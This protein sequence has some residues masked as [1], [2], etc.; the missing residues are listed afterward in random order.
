MKIDIFKVFDSVQWPFL[1]DTFSALNLPKKFIHCI[2]LCITSFSL[3]RCCMNVLSKMLDVPAE[4]SQTGYHPTCKNIWLTHLCFADDLMV[5]ADG[6]K[7][8]IKGI[9][10]V[11][12]E[13]A[14]GSGLNISFEKSTLFL[15]GIEEESTDIL[16]HF[17]L[18][19]VT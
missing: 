13:F 4:K 15:A 19:Q 2:C 10:T 14:K 16:T 8:S 1:L 12:K 9:L 17:F 7:R 3:Q 18:T 5:F 6:T 11:F